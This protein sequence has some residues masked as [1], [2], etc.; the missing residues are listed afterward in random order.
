MADNRYIVT[1][2]NYTVK[3]KHKMLSN[4]STIYERDYMVTSNLGG[5]EDGVMPYGNSNFNYMFIF[6]RF[7]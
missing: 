1:H 7:F 4:D 3:K 2:S 6:Y 5:F